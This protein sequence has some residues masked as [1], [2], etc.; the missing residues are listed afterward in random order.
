MIKITR[1]I[2][3]LPQRA[4]DAHKY[5]CGRALL[6]CG[7]ARYVGAPYFAA[8]ACV[9]SGCGMTYLSIP[10]EIFIPLA[11]KLNE[12]V[13][14]KRDDLDFSSYDAILIGPGIG[15][16]EDAERL[17]KRVIV[18]A[19][20]PVIVDAD[21]LWFLSKNQELMREN[22]ILTPHEGEFKRFE[23]AVDDFP[24]TLVLKGHKTKIYSRGEIYE[25][26]T[27][28]CGMAKG[29]SGDV[30]AGMICAFAAQG[31]SP[32]SAAISGVFYHG[33]AGDVARESMSI[34][35]MTP[36]D[37]LNAIPLVLK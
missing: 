21:A 1:D 4:E 24:C 36:T 31:L 20:C 5:K 13:F 7:S 29:G 37:T 25:N 32:V 33:L 35:G 26:T 9:N 27:G 19:Q 6:V 22:M 17:V 34:L 8:Q 30:L 28:N 10:D 12:P 18:Q 14:L 23:R 3:V 11:S 15:R 16:G 2:A